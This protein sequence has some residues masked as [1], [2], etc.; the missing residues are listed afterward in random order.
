MKAANKNIAMDGTG[1]RDISGTN[2]AMDTAG[3]KNTGAKSTGKNTAMKKSGKEAVM[4]TLAARKKIYVRYKEGA[5]LYS[6]GLSKFQ[7]MAHDA[8]AVYKADKL[9]LV[10]LEIFDAYF[11]TFRLEEGDMTWKRRR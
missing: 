5:A 1:C 4:E 10:N 7:Q 3:R 2:T 6:M 9:C 8:G 11:Q